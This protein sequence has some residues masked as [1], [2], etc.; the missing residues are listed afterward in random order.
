MQDP[1][2]LHSACYFPINYEVIAQYKGSQAWL[3]FL[4]RAAQLRIL[5]EDGEL[6]CDTTQ[7]G[8]RGFTIIFSDT[9]PDS[10]KVPLRSGREAYS[11]RK[12]HAF[13]LARIPS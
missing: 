5:G 12:T 4:A 2:Y 9:D 3:E 6:V 8:S 7:E 13:R 1:N 11:P 10:N